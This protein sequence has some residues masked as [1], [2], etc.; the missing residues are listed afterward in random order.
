MNYTVFKLTMLELM[1]RRRLALVGLLGLLPTLL[2]VAY[3]LGNQRTDPPQWTA[4]V[5]LD[6]VVVTILLPLVALIFG[7]SAIGSEIEDGTIVH[8]LAKPVSR[9]EIILA[10]LASAC[11]LTTLFVLPAAALSGIIAIWGSAEQ[12][13][14]TGF[15]LGSFV[16]ALVYT[17]IFVL[18]SVLTNRALFAGLAY[19]F[20]WEGILTQLFNGTRYLSVHQCCLGVADLIASAGEKTF[21]AHVGGVESLIILAITLVGSVMLAVRLLE[22]FEVGRN[23]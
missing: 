19:V 10:K 22:S 8:L 11:L 12:G 21:S 23:D 15:M 3:Q 1:G 4:N 9:R 17:S 2:A 18:L 5:L 20:L 13:I 14:V 7:T 16:G 6:S